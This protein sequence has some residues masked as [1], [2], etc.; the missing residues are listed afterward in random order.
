MRRIVG[1]AA[2]EPSIGLHWVDASEQGSFGYNAATR[3]YGN[4]FEMGVIVPAKVTRLALQMPARSQAWS[5]P[6][7][8]W[9]QTPPRKE[10]APSLPG[11]ESETY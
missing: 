8:A 11:D 4:L 10:T 7:I 3:E 6:S 1:N 5:W 2:D 9:S